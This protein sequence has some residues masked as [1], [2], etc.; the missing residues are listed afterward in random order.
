MRLTFRQPEW[1]SWA[2]VSAEEIFVEWDPR[3]FRMTIDSRYAFLVVPV[4]LLGLF[5]S[6]WSRR[7]VRGFPPAARVEGRGRLVLSVCGG[8][9]RRAGGVAAAL[10]VLEVAA[11]CR[12][13]EI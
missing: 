13:G 1:E 6:G 5:F 11:N 9:R 4:A 10:A 8:L 7:A 3:R 12:G 2:K